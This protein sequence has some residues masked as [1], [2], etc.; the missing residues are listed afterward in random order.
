MFYLFKEK[1]CHFTSLSAHFPMKT[2]KKMWLKEIPEH[3]GQMGCLLVLEP[4]HPESAPPA[5]GLLRCEESQLVVA[6]LL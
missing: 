1:R 5:K 3:Q 6:S 4:F 2:E